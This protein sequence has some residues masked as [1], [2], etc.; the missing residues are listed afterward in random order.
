MSSLSVRE[1]VT[2]CAKLS[3]HNDQVRSSLMALLVLRKIPEA[4]QVL[5]SRRHSAQPRRLEPT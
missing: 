5:E 3:P 4:S 1:P 2:D